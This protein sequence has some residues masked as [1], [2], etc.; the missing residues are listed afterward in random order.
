MIPHW[1]FHRHK[2]SHV[3]KVWLWYKNKNGEGSVSST[4][5]FGLFCFENTTIQNKNMGENLSETEFHL[6]YPQYG[7]A[8]IISV[9]LCRCKIKILGRQPGSFTQDMEVRR[10]CLAVETKMYMI[11]LL[12][13]C[14]LKRLDGQRRSQQGFHNRGMGM[15][16]T[17]QLRIGSKWAH[18]PLMWSEKAE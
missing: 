11:E 14:S 7:I 18:G 2:F 15:H 10:L 8:D 13:L 5:C 3:V 6:S 16:L 12:I 9:W 17:C 1:Q 4:D